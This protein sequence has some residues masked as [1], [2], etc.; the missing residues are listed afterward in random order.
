MLVEHNF[1]FIYFCYPEVSG[2]RILI[3]IYEKNSH[4]VKKIERP[5]AHGSSSLLAL[6]K[7]PCIRKYSIKLTISDIIIKIKFFIEY[8]YTWL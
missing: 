4:N 8:F 3:E 5:L 1:I 6:Y 7:L 2:V